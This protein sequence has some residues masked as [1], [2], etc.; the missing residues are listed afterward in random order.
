MNQRWLH[1]IGWS[2]FFDF[3]NCGQW[4]TVI[5]VFW[6]L[7]IALSCLALSAMVLEQQ[8]RA[9]LRELQ[10][11]QEQGLQVY[12][13]ALQ[14]QSQLMARELSEVRYQALDSVL[15]R[16]LA[17]SG[18][19]VVLL[20]QLQHM[21]AARQLDLLQLEPTLIEEQE[22]SR[23]FDVKLVFAGSVSDSRHFLSDLARVPYLFVLQQLD[24]QWSPD[25]GNLD[26]DLRVW[27]NDA[28]V[29]PEL[30][31][32]ERSPP[33]TSGG[34]AKVTNH[35]SWERVAWL[36]SADRQVELVRDPGGRLYQ[37]NSISGEVTRWMP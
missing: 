35:E 31:R 21:A 19:L 5:C 27:I 8:V 16:Y 26:V 13:S 3:R 28:G 15:Q 2:D 18:R 12:Q 14:Q 25:A 4:S 22:G 30:A 33:G 9:P 11:R 6:C 7:L 17:P 23:V 36:K 10:E 29:R 1:D 37:H 32:I 24:W 34:M 20:D